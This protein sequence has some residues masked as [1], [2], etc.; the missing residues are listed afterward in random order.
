MGQSGVSRAQSLL[1][2]CLQRPTERRGKA[3]GGKGAGRHFVL[4]A[5]IPSA[6]T[7]HRAAAGAIPPEGCTKAMH[8]W[9]ATFLPAPLNRR[10]CGP[11]VATHSQEWQGSVRTGG[12]P[13]RF[14]R[15]EVLGAVLLP[16]GG[17]PGRDIP[18]RASAAGVLAS[19]GCPR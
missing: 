15:L 5:G 16:P 3:R 6:A 13:F 17:K 4:G 8:P 2:R 14:P 18:H 19:F 11:R 12:N 1:P 7:P 9:P 10:P